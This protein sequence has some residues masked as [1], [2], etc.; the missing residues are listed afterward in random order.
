MEPVWLSLRAGVRLRWRVLAAL[1]VLLGVIS[2][3][4]LTAAEGAR[5]TDT[6]YPRLLHWANAAQVDI[7]PA[8]VP[9]WNGPAGYYAALAQLP[10]V[11]SVGTAVWYNVV[12]P[13]RHG[14]PTTWVQAF[15]SPDHAVGAS[16]DRLKILQGQMFSPGAVGQAVINPQLAALEHL[17]PGDTLH[18]LGVR[19]N[20]KTGIDDLRLTV[21]LAFRVSAVAVFDTQ[22]VPLT[23]VDRSPVALL[24]PPF[25]ATPVARSIIYQPHVGVRLRPGASM[26]AFLNAATVLALRYPPPGYFTVGPAGVAVLSDEVAATQRAIHPQAIALAAFAALAGLI[27]LAIIGQLLARQLLLDAAEFP[28]LRALGMTRGQLAVLSLVRLAAVTVTGAV[29][30]V[31]VAVAASPLMP[32][33]PARLAEPHPGI[34]VNLAVLAAGFALIAVLPL[35]VLMPVAWRAAARAGGPLG[36]AEPTAPAWLSRLGLVPGLAGSVP[37]SAGVRMAFEPGHGRTAVPVRSALAETT[38]AIAAIVAALVFGT[39]LIALVSTPHRYGQ[40]WDQQLDLG[41]QGAGAAFGAKVLAA[42]PAISGYAAGN[43]GQ[44]TINGQAV[45]AA[46]ISPHRGGGFFTLLAGRPPSGP[47]EIVLGAQTLRAVHRRLGQT[48]QVVVNALDGSMGT[49]NAQLTMRVVGVAV[50]PS[51]DLVG[52]AGT[53]LGTGAAVSV[54]LLSAQSA[55]PPGFGCNAH[56]TCHNFF[57]IRY[58]P[59]TDLG[60]AAARLTK[61]ATAAGCVRLGCPVIS[62]QRPGDIQSYADVR[63]TPLVLAAVL[64]LLAVGTLAHVLITGVR[65]RRRDLAVLKTLGLTRSQL[66]RVVSCQASALAMVALLAGLPLGALAGRWS[67]ALFARSAGVAGQADIPLPLVL[68]AIPTVLLLANLIAAGPGWAAAQTR[69]AL[70][71]RSE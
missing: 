18:L 58:K 48:V 64:A 47:T 66:L 56:V 41:F 51:F 27:A 11:A 55:L 33:G 16:M 45:A 38:M 6:A 8:G 14:R 43:Y 25:A 23:A 7:S 62:D 63:D 29:I 57:L 26:S 39:S 71:L 44:L 34:E 35:A 17:R 10:Q 30:A 61:A 40:N 49:T 2:G 37:A 4:V 42:E 9:G 3:V 24:S 22:I 59:G 15:A 60:A 32:I 54:P 28:V 53:D 1:A 13:V 50:F 5:R 31:A 46:G 65:R 19:Y 20:P 70:I 21:P 12:L 69:P 67:W 36:V 68:L 52:M